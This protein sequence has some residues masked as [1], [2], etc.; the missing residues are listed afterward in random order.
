MASAAGQRHRNIGL[1]LT[2][3]MPL[4]VCKLITYFVVGAFQ[5]Q[6]VHR[7]LKPENL[8]LDGRGNIKI[9]DFG[10]SNSFCDGV[11]LDTFCGSPFYAAPEMVCRR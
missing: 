10:F 4:F 8:L 3:H 5:A 1:Q 9:A 6:I 11:L 2:P 7:D